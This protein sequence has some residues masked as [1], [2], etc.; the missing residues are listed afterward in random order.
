MNNAGKVIIL[1]ALKYSLHDSEEFGYNSN[2]KFLL[3]DYDFPK[4]RYYREVEIE[5]VPCRSVSI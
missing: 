2:N 5:I 4:I 1:N 3:F